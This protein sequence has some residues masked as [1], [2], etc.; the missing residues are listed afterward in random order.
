MATLKDD[1]CTQ[2]FE[3]IETHISWVFVGKTEVFKVKRPV[4]LGFLDFS[5]VEKRHSACLAEVQLNSRLAPDVYR[6]VVP[7]TRDAH[8]AHSLSGEGSTVDWA[9]RMRRLREEDRADVRLEEGKLGIEDVRRLARHVADFHAHASSDAETRR[10]GEVDAIRRNVVENFEQ[11]L[12]SIHHYLSPAQ[13]EEVK[14][15]QLAELDDVTR[16]SA[17]TR[18]DRIRDGHGDLRLE[19]VYFGRTGDISII[20]CIEF[21]ERFRYADV[22]ADVAFLSMDFAWHGH[23]DLAE[24]LLAHY[25]WESD[26]YDLYSVV[27]FY[28]SYRAFVRGKISAL[29]A[30]DA[31]VSADARQRARRD[32]RRYFVLSL[33][34]ERPPLETPRVVAV[35]GSIASGKSTVARYTGELLA[36]PVI[37]TDRTRKRLAGRVPSDSMRSRPWS[38]EYSEGAT[39]RVYEEVLRR[40]DVVVRSGRP[41][42]LDASFR[43]SESRCAAHGVAER[44]GVP[45]TFVECKAPRELCLERLERRERSGTHDSDARSDLLD[46]FEARYEPIAEPPPWD[47]LRVDT[48]LPVDR[49]RRLVAEAL[50]RE[51]SWQSPT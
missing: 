22:C 5:T 42:V 13:A 39:R 16:F 50:A 40:A 7:V 20:D 36:A 38:G 47:C 32:A 24:H 46:S 41:V 44:L 29:L 28:E 49:N 31:E 34:F 27:N 3:L 48:S 45:F 2:G 26:D 33:A 35:G 51:P 30:D 6:S 21:N 1:L 9:V 8:G 11:T 23:V 37:S 43:S 19:H 25:A 17:R 4:N 10:H 15:W 18:A 14:A 12:D